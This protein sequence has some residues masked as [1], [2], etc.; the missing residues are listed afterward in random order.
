MNSL[1]Q[2]VW[3]Q[4]HQQGLRPAE[5]A[6]RAGVSVEAVSDLLA[7]E[8]LKD[9]PPVELLSGVAD[10]LGARVDDVV[11]KAAKACGL[12]VQVKAAASAA[13]SAVPNEELLREVRRR[14]A[15]GASAGGYL[16]SSLPSRPLALVSGGAA[17]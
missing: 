2:Y 13:L 9:M 16:A 15:L 14:L 5:L 4:M 7:G 11:L 1:S 10:A 3:T 12:A 6:A 17:G 8:T